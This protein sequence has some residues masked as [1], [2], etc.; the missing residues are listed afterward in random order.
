RTVLL[1][2]FAYSI[3]FPMNFHMALASIL[4]LPIMFCYSFFFLKG[5][6]DRFQK[7][8]EAEGYLMSIAQENFTGVRVV[9][10]F[11]RER[12]EVDRFDKQNHIF[13]DL[14]MQLGKL[15]SVFWGAGD[16]ISGFQIITIC[17]VGA[18][19]AQAGNLTVGGF[20]VFLIYNS[21]TIWPVRGLGRTLSEASKTGVS[22][23]RLKD[24]LDAAPEEDPE[25]A[26]ELPVDGDIVFDHV[27][28]SYEDQKVLDDVSFTIEKG[29]TLGVLGS[30]GS[31][32]TTI[33]HLLCR[34]Y[35]LEPDSGTITIGG[36]SI[37]TF[38]RKWLRSNVGIVL[39]EPFLF[40]R[41]IRDNIASL[42]KRHSIDDIR[43]AAQI[44]CVDDSIEQFSE[45][46]D[47]VV[48]ERGVTLSG[49]QKQRVA[50]A[51]TIIKDPPI[52]I[53]DDSLSAVDTQTDSRI[54]ASLAKRTNESTTI[55]IAYR[56]TSLSQADKIIVLDQGRI[57]ESG[58]HEELMTQNGVY[59]R[60]HDMQESIV[61]E[62]VGR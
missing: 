18:F 10:A 25:E 3:L 32:K 57:I 52:M 42:S 19:Q 37:D 20:M 62:E 30:T 24:I 22:L 48:G 33:A 54:R 7:A 49:G 13:A 12:Y 51:R 55:L 26:I 45:G 34:L 44:A 61:E 41:S 58:S 9:R 43:G 53:F 60:V 15:L 14:W 23:G 35:D 8:D 29:T 27:T 11:G 38:K 4:F 28:F 1:V 39:Q 5:V 21:M 59:R 6:S 56:I 31:G 16:A 46:Y 40:S 36:R 50:I 2:V 47:T 17:I